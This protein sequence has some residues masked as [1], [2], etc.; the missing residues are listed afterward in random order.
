LHDARPGQR[1]Y[2]HSKI[3]DIHNGENAGLIELVDTGIVA[4]QVA[5]TYIRHPALLTFL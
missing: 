2:A 1:I 5:E 4:A 3:Y